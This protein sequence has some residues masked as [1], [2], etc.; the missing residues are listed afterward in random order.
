MWQTY[1][2]EKKKKSKITCNVGGNETE[3]HFVLVGINN[4]VFKRHESNSLRIHR[5]VVA[6]I[7]KRKLK[8]VFKNE[9]TI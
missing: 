9:Q 3:I 6:D 4:K 7:D 5:L 8:K 2:F 1:S